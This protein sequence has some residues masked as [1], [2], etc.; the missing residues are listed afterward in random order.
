MSSGGAR[1]NAGRKKRCDTIRFMVNIQSEYAEKLRNRAK[2]QEK[3]IG[4]VLENIMD[5]TL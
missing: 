4:E 3:T 2:E 1:P 5:A